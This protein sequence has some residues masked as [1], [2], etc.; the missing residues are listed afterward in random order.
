MNKQIT[1]IY[2]SLS[3]DDD[4]TTNFE[5]EAE[6]AIEERVEARALPAFLR[7][8]FAE[9]SAHTLAPANGGGIH[10]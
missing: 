3:S 5:P 7:K 6:V 1:S 2:S 10:G 8:E 9:C 4:I